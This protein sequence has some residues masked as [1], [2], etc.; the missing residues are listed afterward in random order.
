MDATTWF[1]AEA[2]LRILLI[3]GEEPDDAF[4][5]EAFQRLARILVRWWDADDARR[6]SGERERDL[7]RNSQTEPALRNLLHTFLLRCPAAGAAAILEPILDAVDRHPDQVHWIVDG[8]VA[9]EDRQPNTP[10]F[11]SLWKLFAD[12]VRRASW[13]PNID[14]EHPR[15]GEILSSI[16]LTKWW[17]DEIR[18]WRSVEGHIDDVNSL[19]EDLPPSSAMLDNYL[20]FLYHIGERALPE[21]F[22]RIAAR[23]QQGDARAMTRR[24]NTIFMLEVLLQRYVYGRP[25]ELKRDPDRRTA[26]LFLL[27]LL[28]EQGSSAAFRLRDDFV[29][30]IAV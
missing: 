3:L 22:V 17:K 21:A 19:F 18:H 14:Q 26:V 16:F 12:K 20:R 10:Q 7:D 11:W 13:L 5:I 4:A 28:V 8:L 30:P 27:D 29:T 15:G 23:L 1:G 24:S 9:V 6:R 2:E 25:L